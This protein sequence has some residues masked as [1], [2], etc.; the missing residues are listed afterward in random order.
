MALAIF[1]PA[2]WGW[3]AD[4]TGKRAQVVQIVAV[5][6]LLTFCGFFM[7][8]SFSWMFLFM[9]L[10]SFFW[11][12]SLPLMEAITLS[13]LGE[14]TTHYGRIRSWGSVGFVIAVIAVGIALDK[15]EIIWLL[16]IVWND[17]LNV[18]L[19]LRFFR[20]KLTG[21]TGIVPRDKGYELFNLL[22][23]FN[24]AFGIKVSVTSYFSM[25]PSTAKIILR[26][27]FILSLSKDV[28]HSS[29]SSE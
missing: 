29:T 3:V 7:G 23:A 27:L 16:W 26:N 1:S 17:I 25:N 11:S 2:F 12:A 15:I 13:H 10:M 24:F 28:R 22:K 4:H 20:L 6:G 19:N 5:M 8:D 21:F 9:L 18:I 14:H